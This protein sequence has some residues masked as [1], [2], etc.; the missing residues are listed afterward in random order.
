[1][2]LLVLICCS[3]HH[4]RVIDGQCTQWEH[5]I[6][7]RGQSAPAAPVVIPIELFGYCPAFQDS[8]QAPVIDGGVTVILN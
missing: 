6:L 2:T 5:R 4:A 7:N 3:T 1:M 8:A